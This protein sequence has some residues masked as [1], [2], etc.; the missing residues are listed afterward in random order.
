MF[1]EM[2]STAENTDSMPVK[3]K[4]KIFQLTQE[5]NGKIN[6]FLTYNID[7]DQ[8]GFQRRSQ[9]LNNWNNW[10]NNFFEGYDRNNNPNSFLQIYNSARIYSLSSLQN[11]KAEIDTLKK[12]TKE[13]LEKSRELLLLLQK[14]GSIETVHDYAEIFRVQA[15][16]HS[17]FRFSWRPSAIKIGIAQIWLLTSILLI[18]VLGIYILRIQ[19]IIPIDYNNNATI[20]TFQFITRLLITSFLIF[21]ISF[22]LRQFNVHN[23]LKTLNTHRQNTLD[24]F[25]LFLESIDSSDLSTRHALMMEVAKSIYEAGQ[26]GFIA[27]KDGSDSNAS[28]IELTKFIKTPQS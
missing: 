10:Y 9:I 16:K 21:L 13:A 18:G 20:I 4:D 2:I 11:S 24:S 8:N 26:S 23:H 22:A 15:Q 14:K 7:Q 1:E 12:E 3:L 6:E 17:N 5:F 27:G 25:K 28:I 19:D